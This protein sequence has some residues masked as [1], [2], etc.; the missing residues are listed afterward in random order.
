MTETQDLPGA[1][2]PADEAVDEMADT[3]NDREIN[4]FDVHPGMIINTNAGRDVHVI[5]VHRE[6]ETEQVLIVGFGGGD[7][8]SWPVIAKLHY[9]DAVVWHTGQAA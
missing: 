9:C 4:A 6:P 3:S 2:T 8:L 7:R 1:D 5:H